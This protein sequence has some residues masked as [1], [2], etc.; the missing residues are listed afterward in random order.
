[1]P[2]DNVSA[3]IAAVR[4]LR[5]FLFVIGILHIRVIK[6]VCLLHCKN[7]DK[8]FNFHPWFVFFFITLQ[9]KGLRL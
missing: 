6:I 5:F 7:N 3:V 9:T 8:S 4:T 1:M 2:V